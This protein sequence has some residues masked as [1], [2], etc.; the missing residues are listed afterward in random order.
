METFPPPAATPSVISPPQVAHTCIWKPLW[1]QA[2]EAPLLLRIR[3]LRTNLV[4][5][6]DGDS[7]PQPPC[8]R[9]IADETRCVPRLFARAD[10]CCHGKGGSLHICDVSKGIMPPNGILNHFYQRQKILIKV[11]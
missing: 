8:F 5:I 4:H 1:A 11:F 7:D 2:E 3:N 10:G 6:A 9:V